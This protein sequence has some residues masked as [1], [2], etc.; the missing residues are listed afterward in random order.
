MWRSS[1][2]TGLTAHVLPL[3]STKGLAHLMMEDYYRR[4]LTMEHKTTPF[5]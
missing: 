3:V 5:I 1:G 2:L 4:T